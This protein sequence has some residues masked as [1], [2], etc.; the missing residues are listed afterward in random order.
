MKQRNV[1]FQ[2]FTNAFITAVTMTE[3]HA[4]K[5][6]N[7]SKR[8]KVASIKIFKELEEERKLLATLSRKEERHRSLL[9]DIKISILDP[10]YGTPHSLYEMLDGKEHLPQTKMAQDDHR[11]IGNISP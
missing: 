7:V 11:E 1:F 5:I 8:L 2:A 6:D 10:I 4:E 3:S 9:Q